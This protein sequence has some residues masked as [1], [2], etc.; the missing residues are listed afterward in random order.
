MEIEFPGR[1]PDRMANV[2]VP[3]QVLQR[4]GNGTWVLVKMTVTSGA[5]EDII[6]LE[7]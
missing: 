1:I 6:D 5:K 3:Q 4:K 7:M 2:A